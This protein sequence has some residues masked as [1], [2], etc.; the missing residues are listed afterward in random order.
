MTPP[1]FIAFASAADRLQ[2]DRLVNAAQ[3]LRF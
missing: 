3:R 1:R 2:V